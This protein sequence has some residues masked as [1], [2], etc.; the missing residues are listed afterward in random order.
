MNYSS[1]RDELSPWRNLEL[2]MTALSNST[3]Y[4][5]WVCTYFLDQATSSP[6]ENSHL[7]IKR[8]PCM[9]EILGVKLIGLKDAEISG[10]ILFLSHHLAL[11]LW[12]I[13]HFHQQTLASKFCSVWNISLFAFLD[14][15]LT[16][17]H[18]ILLSVQL[19][20][21]LIFKKKITHFL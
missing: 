21:F 5:K 17:V 7:K 10:T 19:K 18:K 9:M 13:S 20:N 4:V 15:D 8:F 12:G 1:Y 16:T 14:T 2:R 3:G 11:Q 6:C